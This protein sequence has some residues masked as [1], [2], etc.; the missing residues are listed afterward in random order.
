MLTFSRLHGD[1]DSLSTRWE[2]IYACYTYF[3]IRIVQHEAF[4]K[5]TCMFVPFI[6]SQQT[7]N[8]RKLQTNDNHGYRTSHLQ[9]DTPKTVFSWI[10]SDSIA[11][12]F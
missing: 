7:A 9:I 5:N 3:L 1:K 8:Y 10:M 12:L 4:C 11:R 6:L 2:H